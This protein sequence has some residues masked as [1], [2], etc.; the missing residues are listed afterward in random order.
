MRN[1]KLFAGVVS[2]LAFAA[3]LITVAS[4]IYDSF[5]G[6]RALSEERVKSHGSLIL[7]VFIFAVLLALFARSET[8][9]FERL[10]LLFSWLYVLYGALILAFV[11]Y[12]AL[13]AD[14][15]ET[16]WLSVNLVLVTATAGLGFTVMALVSK[17]NL[18][19]FAAPFMLVALEHIGMWVM[20]VLM[21]NIVL[22]DAHFAHEMVLFLYTG[23][24]IAVLLSF[25]R[26][27]VRRGR[28]AEWET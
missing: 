27:K 16:Q 10:W 1:L 11:V 25:Q 5:F 24:I 6:G 21:G 9:G 26:L 2:G 8:E 15:I 23:S 7:I 28:G 4:F 13:R 14:Q 22:F 19:Y 12:T 18:I 17:A 20:K 3:N